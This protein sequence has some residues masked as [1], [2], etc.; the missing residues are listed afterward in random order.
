MDAEPF[1]PDDGEI[2]FGRLVHYLVRVAVLY[3]PDDATLTVIACENR[4][5]V[6]RE[7]FK[8]DVRDTEI[9]DGFQVVQTLDRKVNLNL[10]GQFTGLELPVSYRLQ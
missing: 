9:I 3:N 2:V 6:F 10:F 4:G 7:R 1:I 5:G 8:G